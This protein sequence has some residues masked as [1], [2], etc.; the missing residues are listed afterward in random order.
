MGGLGSGWQGAK[1]ATVEETLTLS[2]SALIQKRALVPGRTS[3]GIWCWSWPGA[4]EPYARIGYRADLSRTEDATLRLDYQ[5]SKQPVD[6]TIR[7]EA[8]HPNYGGLRWWFRCPVTGRRASK[9]HL[10]PGARLFACRQA[11]GLTYRSCQESGQLRS[12][13]ASIGAELGVSPHD[14]ARSL[15]RTR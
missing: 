12:L 10:P 5:V 1:R 13:F 7:L 6:A 14:V 9:L 3:V 15:R 8:T 4:S 11:H 2:M